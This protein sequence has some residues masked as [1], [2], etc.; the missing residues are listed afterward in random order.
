MNRQ[1]G[2]SIIAIL[3]II[4]GIL[5]IGGLSYY[6]LN[7]KDIA[8]NLNEQQTVQGQKSTVSLENKTFSDDKLGISIS[9]P[10]NF[11]TE[12]GIDDFI[13]NKKNESTITQNAEYFYFCDGVYMPSTGKVCSGLFSFFGIQLHDYVINQALINSWRNEIAYSKQETINGKQAWIVKTCA[14]NGCHVSIMF[15][16]PQGTISVSFYNNFYRD[17]EVPFFISESAREI[18]NTLQF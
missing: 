6:F 18:L 7:N 11:V 4:A 13:Y 17:G 2:F 5:V 1:K 10:K 8:P 9:F 12:D 16:H 14:G 3:L 15:N